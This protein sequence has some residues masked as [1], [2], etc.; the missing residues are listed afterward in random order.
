MP[1]V[2]IC[3][4]EAVAE[5]AKSEAAARKMST[6]RFIACLLRERRRHE[7]T[8]ERLLASKPV[9]GGRHRHRH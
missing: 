2:S 9:D 1:R 8:V 7:R 3:L 4:D 6:S 5:W